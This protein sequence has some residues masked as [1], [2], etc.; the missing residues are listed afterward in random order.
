[1]ND[2]IELMDACKRLYLHQVEEPE[3]NVLR[4]VIKEAVVG[5]SYTRTDY[6]IYELQKIFHDAPP[7]VHE[8]SSKVF[9]IVW[10]EYVAY[11]VR[12][13]R[14]VADDTSEVKTGRLFQEYSVSKY[15]DFVLSAT[16]A[17]RDGLVPLKHVGICCIDHIIDVVSED[18]PVIK[19]SHVKA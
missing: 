8:P 17:G 10:S 7:I 19:V 18:A 16:F 14:F 12:N 15:L 9:E 6:N 4:L 5:E 3:P 11:S 2:G 13:E 1:M